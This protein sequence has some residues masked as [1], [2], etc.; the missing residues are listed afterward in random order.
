MS[1]VHAAGSHLRHQLASVIQ[2][3]ESKLA[4]RG[5]SL[6]SLAWKEPEMLPSGGM[7]RQADLQQGLSSEQAKAIVA[8]IK[9]LGLK[10]QPRID[11]DSVRVAGRQLDDLQA[12][13][14]AVRERDFGVPLQMENYR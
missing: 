14:R 3:L 9:Q 5:V 12:V 6:R 4:K 13:M 1:V 2:V 10:V 7:K 11:A 8:A